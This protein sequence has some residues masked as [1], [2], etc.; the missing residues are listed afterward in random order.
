MARVTDLSGVKTNLKDAASG[1]KDGE[2]VFK[3]TVG[4]TVSYVVAANKGT[5]I[6]LAATAAG[7]SAEEVSMAAVAAALS[8]ASVA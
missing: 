4:D 2:R 6:R 8:G 3:A 5:A 7:V 1:L